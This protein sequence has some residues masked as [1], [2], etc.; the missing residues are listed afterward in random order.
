MTS[1]KVNFLMNPH[2]F[3]LPTRTCCRH[4]EILFYFSNNELGWV[5]PKYSFFLLKSQFSCP[6]IRKFAKD[7]HCNLDIPTLSYL[8]HVS[9][10]GSITSGSIFYWCVSSQILWNDIDNAIIMKLYE[11]RQYWFIAINW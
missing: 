6:K 11:L 7:K 4:L 10:S 9:T 1:I 3:W 8:S 5:F 2:I